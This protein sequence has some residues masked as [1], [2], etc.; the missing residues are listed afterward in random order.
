MKDVHDA[1]TA[2]DAM[3]DDKRHKHYH[4]RTEKF[5]PQYDVSVVAV[6]L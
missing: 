2:I 1:E 6:R 4:Q 5:V 3:P